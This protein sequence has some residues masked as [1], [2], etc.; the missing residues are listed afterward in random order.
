MVNRL[1]VSTVHSLLELHDQGWSARRI[2][3]E[4]GLSRMTVAR[5]LAAHKGGLVAALGHD[6]DEAHPAGRGLQALPASEGGSPGLP[7]LTAMPL[8]PGQRGGAD[9]SGV[10][11][12]FRQAAGSVSVI[13]HDRQSGPGVPIGS[14][15]SRS[16]CLDHQALITEA[17]AQGLTAQ[18][19]WQDLVA[20]HGFTGGYDSVKRFVR[21][22]RAAAPEPFRRLEC[23][24]GAEAQVDF[25]QGAWVV[26]EAGARRRPHLLRLVLSHSRK[27]YSEAV[28]R[29]DTESLIRVLENAFR[30]WG[31][32]PKT[33]VPDNMKCAVL[34]ADWAD[35]ELNHKLQDF[36]RHYGTVLL[37]T[38]VRTPRHKGKVERAIG[39][40]QDNALKGRTFRT[41]AE[42][43][44]HLAAWERQVA[45][46]RLH[47]TIRQQVQAA[48]AR[49]QPA[50]LPLP[51]TL[52]PCF[53]EGP[54]QVH[55]D[56]HVEVA[57]SYYSAPPEF[58]RRQLWVRW[59]LRTVQ[60]LDPRTM[61]L[62]RHHVRVEPGR[63]QTHP[64]DIPPRKL[65]AIER[66]EHQLL[67]ELEIFGEAVHGWA[68]AMLQARGIA[69]IRVLIGVRGLAQKQPLA[70][71]A[72]AC[73]EARR[74][75]R[76]RLDD[77][78][79]LLADPRTQQPELP[80]A[81]AHPMI[82]PLAEYQQLVGSFQFPVEAP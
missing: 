39:Y 74:L 66:G 36:C 40:A 79:A 61:V 2:A 67:Q 50:L 28:W 59:D 33:L 30:A 10:S 29:Q 75:Q 55:R 27:G 78:R 63:H 49:E 4:L 31:G 20:T 17:L 16:L 7:G 64:R 38:K 22:Q 47:G 72:A 18:R 80:L 57:K 77:L 69:G 46:T 60:L 21:R 45:D 8:E 37:P 12:E 41:L 51:E 9:F 3:R 35:P 58:V 32:V 42:Q 71:L 82:R 73:Q 54:R 76:W 15:G 14:D 25:G 24:P 26:N 56:G 5:H 62:V 43:N 68:K 53:D 48:F 34:R 23:L 81:Q 65:A 52:F 70:Q 19:I 1:K 13:N 6:A 11:D 44:T